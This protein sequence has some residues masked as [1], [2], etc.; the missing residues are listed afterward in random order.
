VRV[1]SKAENNF[2]DERPRGMRNRLCQRVMADNHAGEFPGHEMSQ[3][4][5]RIGRRIPLTPSPCPRGGLGS[6]GTCR[7]RNHF[8]HAGQC[9]SALKS[10]LPPSDLHHLS[11][12][13][14]KEREQNF[15]L[16]RCLDFKSEPLVLGFFA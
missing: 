5:P 3:W 2:V 7:F 6:G 1:S 16:T 14:D 13:S 11:L 12:S 10:P 9:P 4:G 8:E 15:I